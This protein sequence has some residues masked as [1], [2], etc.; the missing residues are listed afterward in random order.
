V[1]LCRFLKIDPSTALHGSN[2]KFTRRFKY[3]EKRMREA[4][5]IMEAASLEAM[6]NFWNMA[7]SEEGRA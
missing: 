3:V 4:G 1:N 6:E 5:K 7:K 2:A